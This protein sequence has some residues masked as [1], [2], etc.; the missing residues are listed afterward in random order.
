MVFSE[1][2]IIMKNQLGWLQINTLCIFL[3]IGIDFSPAMANY[4]SQE[5][6]WM[7]QDPVQYVDGLNLYEYVSSK[8]II[9][10][11]PFGLFTPVYSPTIR[12]VRDIQ[13]IV[14]T[15]PDGF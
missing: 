3:L 14:G 9:S 7:Q 11:D 12:F 15:F 4:Q 6:R 13:I 8:P 2:K 1:K 5:G 10:I